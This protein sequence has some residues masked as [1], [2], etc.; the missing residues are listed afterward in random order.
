MRS[1]YVEAVLGSARL[2]LFA[3]IN[4]ADQRFKETELLTLDVVVE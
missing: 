2:K 4:L 3:S 1:P